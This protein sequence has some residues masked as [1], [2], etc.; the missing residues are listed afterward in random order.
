M[1][2]NELWNRFK[3]EM[4]IKSD[5]YD[6]WAFG[7][8]PD[9]L[10]NLVLEGKKVATASAYQLYE[11]E[12]EPEPVVGGYSVLLDSKE[13]ARCIIVTTNLTY[14]SFQDVSEEFA[15][16]EGEGDL[17]LN[18]WRKVHQEFFTDCLNDFGEKF[19]EDMIVVCEEFKVVYTA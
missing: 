7:A 6:A 19:S 1:K 15:A 2:A 13:E 17:S 11:L 16:K 3:Q 9:K 5:N 8:S 4:N 14:T 10:L 12:K 18:Y